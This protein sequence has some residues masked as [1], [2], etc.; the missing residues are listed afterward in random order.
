MIKT[1]NKKSGFTLIEMIVSVGV[2]SIVVTTAVGA[3]LVII[4]TNQQL[5]AEQNVMTNLSFALDS[6]T[7]ELRTGSAYFCGSVNSDTAQ[8]AGS[9]T[10]IFQ[11]SSNDHYDLDK[12]YV[13]DCADGNN[14]NSNFH[15]V[16]FIEGGNSISGVSTNRR[17]MYYLDNSDSS[18]KKL[19]RR[20]GSDE[21]QSII[22]SG[23]EIINADF[24][25]TGS[26]LMSSVN[27]VEQPTV[28]IYIEARAKNETNPKTYYLQ[29][30]ITQRILDL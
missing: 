30:T 26:D 1:K 27:D 2:F 20:V 16:S 6:M 9:G 18:D 8:V 5:Q 11:T 22:S 7:R 15:G 10:R 25:V 24:F 17:I 19:M 4:S 21:P 12:S 28:T 3:L 23:L 14:S 29:T 13:R